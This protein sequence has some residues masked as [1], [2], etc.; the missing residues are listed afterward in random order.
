MDRTPTTIEELQQLAE[1]N[2]SP[3]HKEFVRRGSYGNWT[4]DRNREK[5]NG[6]ALNPRLLKD[7]TNRKFSNYLRGYKNRYV[8]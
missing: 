2:M 3:E 5:L 1:I 6:L 4:R 8:D 7:T